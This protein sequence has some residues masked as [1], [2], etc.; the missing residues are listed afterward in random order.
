MM[1]TIK[2]VP[3][4]TFLFLSSVLSQTWADIVSLTILSTN[5]IHS[6]LSPDSE[7]RGGLSRIAAYNKKV[8]SSEKN[9]LILNAGDM[10]SGTAVSSLFK[11]DP[12]FHVLNSMKTD[13]AVLGN[14]DFDYGWQ[15]IQHYRDIAAFP[16]LCANA[17]TKGSQG[18]ARLVGDDA[19]RI[20]QYG[21]LKV[22]VIGVLTE[23]T[24]AM[25]TKF[26]T[27]G[28]T[29]S[30]MV[31][32]LETLVPE[33]S[34][35]SDIVIALTHAGIRQDEII[36]NKVGGID[37]I[38]GGHSHT[39]LTQA[40][41]I[42]GVPIIQAGENGYFIGRIDMTI[43]TDKD[44]IKAF[45]YRL[46]E[47]DASMESDPETARVVNEWESRV[48]KQV[49]RPLAEALTDLSEK[50]MMFIAE[51]AFL[52]STGAD[53]S[54]QNSGGTRGEIQKGVFSYR[55]VWSIFPFENTLVTA[56][57]LGKDIPEHFYGYKPID[58]KRKYKI[59]TNSYVKDQWQRSYPE[60]SFVKWHDT[61]IA[62]RD[63]V[64][65]YME[66]KSRINRIRL[67]R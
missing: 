56:E 65:R 30:P 41:E 44:C 13:A 2:W 26:A 11:G 63:S 57:I 19:Y 6:Y 53:N 5:D 67:V 66:K 43:D 14:H 20:F 39:L 47:V 16:L 37:L 42:N 62:M 36:A 1:K 55:T 12:I 7:D 45:S 52:E 8:R 48:E 60:L 51:A 64:L 34:S 33:V 23:Q 40:T 61:G 59:V 46:I 17:H 32:T 58:P 18:T 49:D 15:R 28:V 4:L 54:H 50:D 3:V 22:A 10:A 29:F 25:T 9:V 24:P 31:Q 38:V 21:A 27:G 35:K